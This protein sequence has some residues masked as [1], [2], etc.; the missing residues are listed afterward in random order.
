MST[1]GMKSHIS[2]FE[3]HANEMKAVGGPAVHELRNQALGRFAELGFPS[4]RQEAWRYTNVAPI[5]RGKYSIAPRTDNGVTAEQLAPHLF[6]SEGITRLVFV[7]GHYRSDLSS[8]G[9]IAPG[10]KIRS[11]EDALADDA[12][13]ILEHLGRHASTENPF[14]A[15]NTAF[16]KNGAVLHFPKGCE[17]PGPVHLLFLTTGGNAGETAHVSHPRLLVIADEGS[18]ATVVESYATIGEGAHFTNVVGEFVIGANADFQHCRVQSESDNAFHVSDMAATVARD[19]RFTSHVITLGGALTRNGITATLADENVECTLNGLYLLSGRQ[20][21]DNHTAIEHRKPNGRSWEVYKG[22]LDDKSTGVFR[23]L[24]HVY[25][26]AQK[27]D[28]KQSNANL[29]LSK[30]ATANSKPQLEI[31]ADDVKCTHG[32]TI[33]QMDEA[34]LF[35]LR[36]RGLPADRAKQM[37]VGAFAHEVSAELPIDGLRELVDARL[38]AKLRANIQAVRA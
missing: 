10:M 23:G 28:A 32:A 13:N 18:K 5:A 1:T 34:A 21:L 37:L 30:D 7:N 16:L 31:Y 27:T 24:I 35:Y 36:S 2:L 33:G 3:S 4:A 29:L 38:D 15:L 11:L 17:A 9:P 26:D 22:I 25:E 14:T 6:E 19:G 20:H 8:A 12:D